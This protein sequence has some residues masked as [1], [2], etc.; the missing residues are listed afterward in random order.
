MH[1]FIFFV[2]YIHSF[3]VLIYNLNLKLSLPGVVL[4]EVLMLYSFHNGYQVGMFLGGIPAPFLH[5]LVR[6]KTKY[7]N[8]PLVAPNGTMTC[9]C[10]YW[11]S[12]LALYL[13]SLSVF[14]FF[15]ILSRKIKVTWRL[16]MR[17]YSGRE[18]ALHQDYL[19]SSR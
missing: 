10:S 13:F 11:H 3:I 16:S 17:K 18:G 6:L 12:H 7:L 1:A 2:R 14:F 5:F 15:K 9:I 4:G 8:M 19:G